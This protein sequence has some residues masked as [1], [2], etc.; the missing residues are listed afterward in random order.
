MELCEKREIPTDF[1]ET[2]SWK[3]LC[4]VRENPITSLGKMKEQNLKI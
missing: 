3:Y 2:L 1:G 4:F